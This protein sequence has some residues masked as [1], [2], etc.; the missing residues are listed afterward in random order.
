MGSPVGKTPSAV[1]LISTGALICI[2]LISEELRDLERARFEAN[3][4]FNSLKSAK[5]GAEGRS[6]EADALRACR[7]TFGDKNW[8]AGGYVA[9]FGAHGEG[10]GKTCASRYEL[11]GL[12]EGSGLLG[13][14][15]VRYRSLGLRV[16]ADESSTALL[17]WAHSVGISSTLT[18]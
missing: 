4:S 18:A 2:S 12:G 14:T 13:G 9:D 16:N 1:V 6:G 8:S 3:L 11:R 5:S 15:G 17:G 7:V 10:K